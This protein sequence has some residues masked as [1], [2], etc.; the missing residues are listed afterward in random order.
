MDQMDQLAMYARTTHR[1]ANQ[2]LSMQFM[3][4]VRE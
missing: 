3:P 2:R 4:I 1:F